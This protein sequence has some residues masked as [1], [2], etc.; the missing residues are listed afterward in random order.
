MEKHYKEP[1]LTLPDALTWSLK[2]DFKIYFL[3][4]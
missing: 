3:S 2:V 4:K 1:Y